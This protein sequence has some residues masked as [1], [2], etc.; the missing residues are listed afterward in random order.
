[1]HHVDATLT[2]NGIIIRTMTYVNMYQIHPLYRNLNQES[3]Y[4][5]LFIILVT[6]LV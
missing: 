1:M 5:R 6:Q 4:Q 3:N 2:E